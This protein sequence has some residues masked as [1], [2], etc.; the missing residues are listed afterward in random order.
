MADEVVTYGEL[1]QKGNQ[2]AGL[3]KYQGIGPGDVFATVMEN[4]P[5]VIISLYAALATGAV[6][7]PLD[8]KSNWEK[9][10]YLL[11]HGQAKGVF[12]SSAVSEN[13]DKVLSVLPGIKVLGISYLQN[14][15]RVRKNDLQVILEEFK[16]AEIPPERK[17]ADNYAMILYTSGTTGI[18]K[19]V[20]IRASRLYDYAAIAA[21]ILSICRKI[22]FIRGCRSP[23]AMPIQSPSS[24]LCFLVFRR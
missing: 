20:K 8:P 10:V 13:M 3:L 6:L 11:R 23:M 7:M 4:R 19:G 16:G 24:P 21:D 15:G 9:L 18:P 1:V 22:A 12:F 2:L 14:H 17:W 5:E